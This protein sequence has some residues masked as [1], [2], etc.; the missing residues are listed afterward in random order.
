MTLC[1]HTGLAIPE[2]SCSACI[3][4]QL[5]Q[6]QQASATPPAEPQNPGVGSAVTP[7]SGAPATR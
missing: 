2:C 5:E 1:S 7:Q 3:R 6:H 4:T